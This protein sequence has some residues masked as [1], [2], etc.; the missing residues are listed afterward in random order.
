MFSKVAKTLARFK[1]ACAYFIA[2]SWLEAF[3]VFV[4]I[5]FMAFSISFFIRVLTPFRLNFA[6]NF[7]GFDFPD[8]GGGFQGVPRETLKVIFVSARIICAKSGQGHGPRDAGAVRG[9]CV[10]ARRHTDQIGQK[11]PAISGNSNY[12]K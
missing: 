5:S 10:R 9:V 3:S 1:A 7:C 11:G 6:K 4:A 12:R 2:S 8:K